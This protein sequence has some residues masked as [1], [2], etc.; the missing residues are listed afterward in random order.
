[1]VQGSSITDAGPI[2]YW[3]GI[4]SENLKDHQQAAVGYEKATE[5]FNQIRQKVHQGR[6]HSNLG[7]VHEK[8]GN[9]RRAM[10]EFEKAVALNPKDSIA[11]FNIG[12]MY[13]MSNNRG[14]SEYE[15]ALDAFACAI[16][17]D[18]DMYSPK[19]GAQ[20]HRFSYTVQEDLRE[21]SKRVINQQC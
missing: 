1:M 15:L 9:S 19:V 16:L 11:H 20:I 8:L 12:M 2:Y 13:F 4:H 17:A 10:E 21:I 14:D 6:A 18:P 5:A 7:S 3:L